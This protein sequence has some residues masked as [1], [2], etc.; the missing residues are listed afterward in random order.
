MSSLLTPKSATFRCPESSRKMFLSFQ[1]QASKRRRLS[2]GDNKSF[3][4]NW[5]YYLVIHTYFVRKRKINIK[6][7]RR[8]KITMNYWWFILMQIIHSPTIKEGKCQR[9]SKFSYCNLAP[10][11]K[12]NSQFHSSK[13]NMCSHMYHH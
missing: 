5:S 2:E 9:S 11:K 4:Q 12:I 13:I 8:L 10:S 3:L 1:L 6:N 7:L